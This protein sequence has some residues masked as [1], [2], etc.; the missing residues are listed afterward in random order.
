MINTRFHQ[1]VEE[2]HSWSKR[3]EIKSV[4]FSL[5]PLKTPELYLIPHS[6]EFNF[7][8][9]DNSARFSL[10]MNRKYGYYF[11]IHQIPDSEIK[12]FIKISQCLVIKENNEPGK[13]KEHIESFS[14]SEPTYVLRQNNEL[15]KLLKKLLFSNDQNEISQAKKEAQL[16]LQS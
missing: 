8:L 15:K 1:L 16:L 12:N 13:W 4:Y 14:Y 3:K 9:A 7:A 11:S 6:A 10:S 2:I 5:D